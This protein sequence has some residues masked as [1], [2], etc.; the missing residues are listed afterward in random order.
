MPGLDDRAFEKLLTFLKAVPAI[1]GPIA[2]S[3][4]GD[5]WW[6]KFAIDILDP[7]AWNVVQEFG[8]V[9]NELSVNERLPTVFKPVSPPPYLNGG[10]RD[11]LSWVI[12]GPS[13]FRP[14]TCAEWL[15]GRL[16][17]PVEDRESWLA[18]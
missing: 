7:L 13:E 3:S 11:F 12:E 2:H 10:P 8:Y 14:G 6:V 5:G 17:Q 15:I 4:D 16:P 1:N 18:E 9:L